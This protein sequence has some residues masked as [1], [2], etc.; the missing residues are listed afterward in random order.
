MS[1]DQ[2]LIE[3]EHASKK[4]CRGLKRSLWYGVCDI[5]RELLG[6]SAHGDRLRL[7]EFW[8]V[9]D[10]SFKIRRGECVGLIGRNGAGKSSLLKMLNGLV[11]PDV[12]RITIRG[13]VAALIELG[14]GFN[15]IL[16]GRENVYNNAAILGMRKREVDSQLD[17]IIE[18]AGIGDA[19]ETPVRSYS[20]GMKVRLGFAVAA[21]LQPD[22]LLID[23][24]LAVGDIGFRVKCMNRISQLLPTT[25]VVFV[26]HNMP[27]VS[28][29]CNRTIVMEKGQVYSDTCDVATGIDCY[30]SLV[31][32][33]Q[34]DDLVVC[35]ADL[36]D[37]QL[38]P[39]SSPTWNSKSDCVVHYGEDLLIRLKLK[40]LP[41]VQRFDLRLIV[42]SEEIP[43][44]DCYSGVDGMKFEH[45][46]SGEEQIEVRLPHVQLNTGNY[47]VTVVVRD[48]THANTILC[49]IANA[50]HFRVLSPY[51]SWCKTIASGEWKQLVSDTGVRQVHPEPEKR[52]G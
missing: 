52:M 10:V 18:F 7:R 43:L 44:V 11:K 49:R 14:T 26:S 13:K 17:K 12:G 36:S 48:A 6:R 30:H 42:T 34:R 19:L 38:R 31:E 16:T 40:L 22:V 33:L 51:S 8:A 24:V 15:P 3:V 37:I 23:E 35:G 39:Q 45:H 9:N 46:G 21:Q 1:D 41:R 27:H 5:T 32:I 2:P 25:A 47:G 29:I 50:A 4:F 20:A 28:R